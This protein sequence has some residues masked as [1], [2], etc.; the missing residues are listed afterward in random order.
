MNRQ[1]LT[2][3]RDAI[4]VVL[5]WPDS[6]CTQVAAWLFPGLP[7]PNGRDPH[8]PPLASADLEPVPSVAGGSTK[9]EKLDAAS[10]SVRQA[11]RWEKLADVPDDQFEAALTA[12]P[13]HPVRRRYPSSAKTAEQRLLTALQ[14]H[15]GASVNALAKAAG[16]NRSSAGERLRGLAS[17]G[18]VTKDSAGRWRLVAE[19][20]GGAPGP[21]AAPPS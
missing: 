3:L 16:A 17:R 5:N 1:E 19:L 7:K 11:E 4:N 9:Q 10:V 6:V 21:T 15:S 20:A 14:E 8:P 18:V 13:P 12:P 2:A